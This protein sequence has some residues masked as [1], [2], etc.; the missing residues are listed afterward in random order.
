MTLKNTESGSLS[1]NNK[2]LDDVKVVNPYEEKSSRA[3]INALPIKNEKQIKI[4]K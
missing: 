3:A 1:G 4:G 2:G